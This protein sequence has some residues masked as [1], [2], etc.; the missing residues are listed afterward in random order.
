MNYPDSILEQIIANFDFAYMLVINVVTFIIIK[1]IDEINGDKGIN[2][3]AKR[4]VLLGVI[5]VITMVY[6]STGYDRY[7]VLANSACVAPVAWTW[8][9]K[10]LVTKLGINYKKNN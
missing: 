3:W 8:V 9:L 4:G 7:T 1:L 5:G 10:P 2:V 6:V